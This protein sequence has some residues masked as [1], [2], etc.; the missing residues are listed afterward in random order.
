MKSRLSK[1]LWSVFLG[2]IFMGAAALLAQDAA[3]AA[4][5]G[6]TVLSLRQQAAQIN[7]WT[8]ERLTTILPAL[9]RRSGIDMWLVISREY[10]ED[11]LFFTLVQRPALCLFSAF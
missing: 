10:Q 2:L 7:A 6:M 9:M 4:P 3:P 11:P 8:E 5:S 1:S